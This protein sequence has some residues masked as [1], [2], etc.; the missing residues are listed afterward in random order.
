MDWRR[1]ILAIEPRAKADV[2][3]G[4]AASMDG[5]V[6]RAELTTKPRLADF[7]A[8][9]AHE[10]AGFKTTTEYATGR[11]YE[12]RRDLGNTNPGDGARF[13]GRGIFQITGRANYLRYG[14]KIN[15]D[16]V[17]NPPLAAQFPHA[18]NTA[19]E[20]WKDHNL[21][22]YADSAD[23][24]GET[25]RINGGLNGLASRQQYRARALHALSDLKSALTVRS[26][27]EAKA[28]DTKRQGAATALV[29][30]GS[31]QIAHGVKRRNSDARNHRLR[32]GARCCRCLALEAI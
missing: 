19:A 23:F 6:A 12:G 21:N 30:G 20:Y 11:A 29:T 7:L 15:A 13:K 17:G 32:A 8:Q 22:R 4:V 25:R 1:I 18:L 26:D 5:A 9:G 3:N 28:G 14:V 16:L 2:V 10:S 31:A 27:E 24:Q